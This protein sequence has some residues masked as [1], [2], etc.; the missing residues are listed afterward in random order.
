MYRRRR[1]ATDTDTDTHLPTHKHS[2][3]PI[4]TY[5]FNYIFTPNLILKGFLLEVTELLNLSD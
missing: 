3:I 4:D 2:N 1:Q 5:L